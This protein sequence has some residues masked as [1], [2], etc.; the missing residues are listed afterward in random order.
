MDNLLPHCRTALET[1][2]ADPAR[3]GRLDELAKSISLLEK[4]VRGYEHIND[5][6]IKTDD[7]ILNWAFSETSTDFASAIW[8]LASGFYK[9]SAASLRNALDIAAASLYFQIREN[10]APKTGGYNRFFAEWDRGDRDTPNWGEMKP[11]IQNQPSI[12]SFNISHHT[13]IVDYAY[14]HFKH[15]CA[16]THTRAFA[17]NGDPVTSINTTGVSPAFNGHLFDRGCDMTEK[18]IGVIAVL[19]QVVYPQIVTTKPLGPISSTA[20]TKLFPLPHG[21]SALMHK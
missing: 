20:Y 14:S 6:A 2:T 21:P 18:T 10:A 5:P 15:L 1:T 12:K 17:D 3:A 16:Y 13:D 19:W 7:E 8:L 11:V 4:F 9:A